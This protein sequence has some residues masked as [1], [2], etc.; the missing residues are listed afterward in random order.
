MH[1]EFRE[2]DDAD[3]TYQMGFSAEDRS[4]DYRYSLYAQDKT[5]LEKRG[6]ILLTTGI[7]YCTA[8]LIKFH[9]SGYIFAAHISP[10]RG[11]NLEK[12]NLIK[13]EDV[14]VIIIT[15]PNAI[16]NA[17]KNQ[18]IIKNYFNKI[19]D[20]L[21]IEQETG[22]H[23]LSVLYDPERDSLY[24]A[25]ANNGLHI[26]EAKS[27]FNLYP[28]PKLSLPFGV[29]EVQ[30]EK[31][32]PQQKRQAVLYHDAIYDLAEYISFEKLFE[33][34]IGIRTRL[35]DNSKK[36]ALL[37]QIDSSFVTDFLHL[38]W[39][40]KYELFDDLDATLILVTE[41]K[42]ISST[43]DD[44]MRVQLYSNES[45]L[46][47]LIRA[48]FPLSDFIQLDT[49]TK[50]YLLKN[51]WEIEF[52]FK[53]GL[54]VCELMALDETL[55]NIL[56]KQYVYVGKLC[57]L[58][59]SI[60]NI[61]KFPIDVLVMLLNNMCRVNSVFIAGMKIL[62]FIALDF[63]V[64]R[65]ILQRKE[66]NIKQL[67]DLGGDV[68]YIMSLEPA[69]RSQLL[70]K[71]RDVKVLVTAGIS[72]SELVGLEPALREQLLEH[73]L[74]V[75]SLVNAGLQISELLKLN[76]MVREQLYAISY[77]EELIRGRV[78]EIREALSAI[79]SKDCK[80]GFSNIL[81]SFFNVQADKKDE[82][83]RYSRSG[84]QKL[85]SGIPA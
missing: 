16:A 20:C 54:T 15:W 12:E 23:H 78:C 84:P 47:C 40:R 30:I 75:K 7:S 19:S 8:I 28:P 22:C 63:A 52:L 39:D 18:S 67:Y 62:D 45:L 10:M 58:E 2:I 4:D 9:Q 61:I 66:T 49:S 76:T 79:G 72:I 25:Y 71:L 85:D 56:L 51:A 17:L 77:S 13:D 35:L 59:L 64:Q 42:K 80:K 55:R 1:I 70:P 3:L 65:E 44:E 46:C 36:I 82:Q 14:S 69:L 50:A 74:D 43:L 57:D 48:E 11:L 26:L 37:L 38:N 21:I 29:D 27:V 31:L 6:K 60:E 33:I 53:V 24:L 68:S 5:W 73:S 34:E 41:M 81:V 83:V 32:S